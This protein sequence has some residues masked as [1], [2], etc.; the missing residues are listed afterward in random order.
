MYLAAS[1]STLNTNFNSHGLLSG[2]SDV[3]AALARNERRLNSLLG[4]A[5]PIYSYDS[6]LSI[7]CV[8]IHEEKAI[9]SKD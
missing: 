2:E 9:E 5:N 3:S 8:D 7:R 1:S 4:E 6:L